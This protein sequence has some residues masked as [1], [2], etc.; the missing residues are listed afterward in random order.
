VV[1][2]DV[3]VVRTRLAR[4]WFDEGPVDQV[5]DECPRRGGASD[6]LARHG[7]GVVGRHSHRAA[8]EQLVVERPQTEAVVDAFGVGAPQRP[9]LIAA[10]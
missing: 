7:D 8:V 2:A 6:E 5:E 9:A 1:P 4:L 10:A 3:L